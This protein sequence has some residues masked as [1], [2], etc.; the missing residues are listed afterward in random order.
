MRLVEP[1]GS[2]KQ[3]YDWCER[4]ARGAGD[5]TNLEQ[6]HDY[7]LC[8][9]RANG[10]VKQYIER[11]ARGAN[12][13]TNLEK[14]HDEFLEKISSLVSSTS[15]RGVQHGHGVELPGAGISRSRSRSRRRSIRDKANC[16]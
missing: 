5:E 1:R 15:E 2:V 8:V 11:V 3:Y 16:S 14:F 7:Y 9:G 13:E 10:S 12:D 6:F 4:F